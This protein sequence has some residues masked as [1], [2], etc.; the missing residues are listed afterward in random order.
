MSRVPVVHS[1]HPQPDQVSAAFLQACRESEEN[2]RGRDLFRSA[3]PVIVFDHFTVNKVH[4]TGNEGWAEV[5]IDEV[6]FLVDGKAEA[7]KGLERQRWPLTRRDKTSWELTAPQGAI[8]VPQH[9]AVRVLSHQLA[10]LTEE[11]PEARPQ[12][13]A[14]LARVLDSLLRE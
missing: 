13:K 1:I 14:E 2:L 7:R 3:Q 6:Y 11:H 5:Q 9:I 10:Q 8:Y 12:Q 4:I